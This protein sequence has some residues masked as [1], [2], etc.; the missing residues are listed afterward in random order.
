MQMFALI[1]LNVIICSRKPWFIHNVTD[2]V[3]VFEKNN[4]NDDDRKCCLLSR[5][6]VQNRCKFL[7]G[8]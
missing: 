3:Y 8:S 6:R 4:D 7:H 2:M 5:K 1:S